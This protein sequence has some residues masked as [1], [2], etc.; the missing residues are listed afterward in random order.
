MPIAV[1]CPSCDAKLNAPDAAA[2]KTVK[3]PKCKEAMVIPDADEVAVEEAAPPKKSKARADDDKPVVKKKKIIVEDDEDEYEEE[4]PRKKKGKKKPAK[5]GLSPVL[6]A[7]ILGGVLILGGGGFAAYWFGIREKPKETANTNN[8]GTPPQPGPPGGGPPMPGGGNLPGP[9]VGGPGVGTPNVPSGAVKPLYEN[10]NPRIATF[11]QIS[12][13]NLKQIGLAMHTVADVYNGSLP[14]GIYDSNGNV[15]LSWRVA[16][17]P[18]IEQESLYKQFKL[19][20]PWNSEHNKKLIPLMPK[21]YAAPGQEPNNGLTYYRSFTGPETAFPTPMRGAAGQPAFGL[22]FS[23]VQDGLSNTGIVVEAGDPVEWTKPDELV[24]SSSG[25]VPRF[26]G[27][28]ADSWHL[29][30]GDGSVRR[31]KSSTPEGTIKA[32]ITAKGGEVVNFDE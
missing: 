5:A 22:K 2:G 18:F 15:G 4:R 21:T 13:N 1:H 30:L 14:A 31:M 23:G 8:P 3:C 24:F 28:F 12:S 26:G 32:I 19:N 6:I 10:A 17:L 29:L 25:A 11:R 16:I 27:I 7:A 9:S 20:E